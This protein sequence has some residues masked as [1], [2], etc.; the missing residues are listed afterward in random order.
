MSIWERGFFGGGAIVLAIIFI[1]LAMQKQSRGIFKLFQWLVAI[2]L[3]L[4]EAGC[5]MLGP[6]IGDALNG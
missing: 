2:A 1:A 3:L 5:W 6:K 4:M